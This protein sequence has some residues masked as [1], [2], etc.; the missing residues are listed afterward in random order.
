MIARKSRSYVQK[1]QRAAIAG[2]AFW[3][4]REEIWSPGAL[5]LY[6]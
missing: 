1:V 4:L 6:L 2:S 3:A 5:N